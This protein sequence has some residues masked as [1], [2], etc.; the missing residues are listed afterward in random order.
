MV[1]VCRCKSCCNNNAVRVFVIFFPVGYIADISVRRIE[2]RGGVAVY[3]VGI[4]GQLAVQIHFHKSTAFFA[5]AGE[6][7][8]AHF[9]ALL[10]QT[11]HQKLALRSFA[12]AVKPLYNY[13]SAHNTKSPSGNAP[14]YSSSPPLAQRS[15]YSCFDI[16]SSRGFCPSGALTYPNCSILSIIFAALP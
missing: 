3:I 14:F 11:V 16:S 1:C 8:R 2:N 9:F 4:A 5:V 15:I 7:Q 12:A 6:A 13:K 10:A